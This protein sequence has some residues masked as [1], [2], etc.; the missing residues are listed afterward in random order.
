MVRISKLTDYG[1]IIMVCIARHAAGILQT[2]EIAEN[3]GLA[4]PTVSKLLKKLTQHQLLTSH[5]G[6]HGGYSLACTP[7]NI[8][9]ADLVS[10]LEGPIAITECNLAH[11]HCATETQCTVKTP[12][13]RI[14]QAITTALQAVHLSDLISTPAHA[15]EHHDPK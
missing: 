7:Q 11:S 12:W 3:T 13:Q 1:I 4:L 5:R 9:V 10:A 2:R 15:R 14:N 8:T 6:T